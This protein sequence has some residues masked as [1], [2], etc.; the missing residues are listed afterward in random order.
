MVDCGL[1]FSAVFGNHFFNMEL[2]S[3]LAFI[4]GLGVRNFPQFRDARGCILSVAYQKEK[5][6]N[7]AGT[8]LLLERGLL[9]RI[10]FAWYRN[11][12]IDARIPMPSLVFFPDCR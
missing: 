12:T 1:Q 10:F 4:G 3:C 2:Y 11:E 6:T 7:D 9:S 8:G 5:K